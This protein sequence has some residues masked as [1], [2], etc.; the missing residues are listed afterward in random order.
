M[1]SRRIP[2]AVE[3]V[4]AAPTVGLAERPMRGALLGRGFISAVAPAATPA[5]ADA[6]TTPRMPVRVAIVVPVVLAGR[7]RLAPPAATAAVAARCCEEGE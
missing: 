4:V 1:R 7:G 5:A 6:E 3:A 2:R